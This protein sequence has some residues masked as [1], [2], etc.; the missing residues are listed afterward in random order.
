MYA[1]VAGTG[2]RCDPM[3]DLRDKLREFVSERDWQQFHT[4]KN[5]SMALAGEAAEIMEIFQWLTAEQSTQLPAEK[6]DEVREEIG[7]VLIYLVRLADVLGIDPM[8]AAL[9]KMEKN[10]VKYPAELAR[11]RADKYTA[12]VK[13]DGGGGAE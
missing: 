4:P 11:G 10:R 9:A 13:K 2:K 12:Y 8:E 1:S 7:D 3:N 5:L 6:M